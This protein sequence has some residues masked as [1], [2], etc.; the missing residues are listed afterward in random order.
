MN[1]TLL[2]FK[3]I[4]FSNGTYIEVSEAEG[5]VLVGTFVINLEA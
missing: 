5:L 4:A 2:L 1:T 3:A